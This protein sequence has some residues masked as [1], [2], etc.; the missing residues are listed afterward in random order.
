MF[1][2]PDTCS[3]NLIVLDCVALIISD[4]ASHYAVCSILPIPSSFLDLDSLRML[5]SNSFFLQGE[6]L[7]S[8]KRTGK[9]MFFF[10]FNR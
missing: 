4:E 8:D 2:V 10:N 1:T 6:V 5:I 3:A 7:H 9:M